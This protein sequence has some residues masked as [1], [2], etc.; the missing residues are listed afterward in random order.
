MLGISIVN[1]EETILNE[2]NGSN[3]EASLVDSVQVLKASIDR[4]IVRRILRLISKKC[5]RDRK[6]RLEIALEL[7]TNARSKSETCFICNLFAPLL[8]SMVTRSAKAFGVTK[9]QLVE[10]FKDPYWRRGLVN[11]VTSIAKFG[12]TKPFVP[13]APF[14]VVWDFT[15]ACNLRCKHCYAS[16]NKSLKDELNTKE[17]LKCVDELADAGVVSIAFSGGEALLR[18]DFFKVASHAS[19]YGIFTAVATNGTLLSKEMVKK[20][21]KMKLGYAQ[22]SLDGACAKT[23]DEFRG[24]PGVFERTFQGIK[25]CVE[26]EDIF[27]EVATTVTKA[28][29]KEIP[30]VVELCRRLGVHWW[31]AYNFVPVGRGSDI[32]DLDLTPF[33]RE[34]MLRYLWHELR[35]TTDLD[36]DVDDVVANKNDED[37]KL[38]STAPQFARIA[39]QEEHGHSTIIPTHFQNCKLPGQLQS[40]SSFIG[41]CGAGRFYGAIRPN[42]NIDPCVFLPLTVGNIKEDDFA[43]LWANN[44]ILR[45]LRDRSKLQDNCGSCKFKYVCGGCRAR[46]YAYFGDITA[47]DPGCVNNKEFYNTIIEKQRQKTMAAPLQCRI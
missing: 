39:I 14:L 44:K 30:E 16:A 5:P 19:D 24:V 7:L 28:N 29:Y 20:L 2:I 27:V 18:K 32:I 1:L 35:S 10:K 25:N 4:P 46:A 23:H 47:P 8:N 37:T 26:A 36:I 41:G 21:Q 6:N 45:T 31:M 22:I 42:G 43:D 40:L 17:A 9:D 3:T 15:Y 33:E 12:V 34:K 38:L 13:V 11:T